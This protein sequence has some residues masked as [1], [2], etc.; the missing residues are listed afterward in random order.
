MYEFQTGRHYFSVRTAFYLSDCQMRP[1]YR[2]DS[3][4]LFQCEHK[5][6]LISK[7]P[8]SYSSSSSGNGNGQLVY[9]FNK[10]DFKTTIK[11]NRFTILVFYRGSWCSMCK[12]QLCKINPLYSKIKKLKGEIIAISAENYDTSIETFSDLALSY[13]LISDEK[14]NLAKKYKV[15]LTERKT[16]LW[17]KLFNLTK[18]YGGNYS[19]MAKNNTYQD[20][21]SQP[22]IVVFDQKGEV[23]FSWKK[24]PAMKNY[25][26]AID[27]MAVEDVLN[28]VEFMLSPSFLE[29]NLRVKDGQ[30]S[31]LFEHIITTPKLKEK[32][33][34]HLK[35]E[36][37]YEL[38]EFVDDVV[39]FQKLTMPEDK[40]R[41]SNFLYDNY[42]KDS[43]PKELNLANQ[44]R[45]NLVK[46]FENE[47][48]TEVKTELFN[49]ALIQAKTILFTDCFKRF[50]K[51]REFFDMVKEVPQYFTTA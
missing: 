35:K 22:A 24:F 37:N 8:K 49:D 47:N 27:R 43:S 31:E 14:N 38:L 2:F 26:G 33:V 11:E 50:Q 3:A 23:I 9:P 36:S 40:T 5:R 39:D 18:Q 51:T 48:K 45:N 44:V 1:N 41:V 6:R 19:R 15:E 7:M 25:Y 4:V 12:D 29:S 46:Y 21:M 34:A 13:P 28:I 20:G 16:N 30:N 10:D 42:I 32:F 17:D